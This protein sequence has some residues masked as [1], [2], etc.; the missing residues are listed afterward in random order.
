MAFGMIKGASTA[1][2]LLL[3]A[4]L[5]SGCAT[6]ASGTDQNVSFDSEP[7]GATVRVAGKVIG[8]TP[9]SA[10]L[11]KKDDQTVSFEMDGYRTVSQSMTTKTDPWFFGNILIGG[12][13]GSTTDFA[14]GAVY[15]YSPDQY[16][17]TL[18]PN[19]NAGVLD[20][21]QSIE[22]FVVVSYGAL[23]SA[24][25][26]S[27]PAD[28]ESFSSLLAALDIDSN[29]TPRVNQLAGTLLDHSNPVA[30]ANAV[31]ARF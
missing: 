17:V 25:A 16:F 20:R 7:E 18:P 10:R 3:A 24:A 31:T 26:T 29:D 27:Q 5:S 30:G 28:D 9:V 13:F 19:D 23:R 2:T 8:Q 22:R 14:S 12:L 15:E 21:K 11:D 1:A 4:S 6:I